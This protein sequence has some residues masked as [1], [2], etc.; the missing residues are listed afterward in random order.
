MDWLLLDADSSLSALFAYF[1]T[2]TSRK[3]IKYITLCLIKVLAEEVTRSGYSVVQLAVSYAYDFG[4][5]LWHWYTSSHLMINLY[6]SIKKKF[7]NYCS[8]ILQVFC[9]EQNW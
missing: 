8:I 7:G 2:L 9:T 6:A 5:K 1:I 3:N 4:N